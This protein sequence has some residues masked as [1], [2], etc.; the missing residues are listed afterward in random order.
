MCCLRIIVVREDG[1]IAVVKFKGETDEGYT[2]PGGQVIAGEGLAAATERLMAWMFGEFRHNG[3]SF[4]FC[5]P[6]VKSETENPT[7][8]VVKVIGDLS[9]NPKVQLGLAWVRVEEAL[10]KYG[11]PEVQQQA[12]INWQR[13]TGDRVPAILA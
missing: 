7:V 1:R 2:L 9:V 8:R 5:R 11:L 12:L 6:A 10:E 3:T 13:I 4:T